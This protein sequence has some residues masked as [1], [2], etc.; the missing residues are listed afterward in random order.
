LRPASINEIK[1]ELS[2]LQPKKLIEL[3]LR[4]AK[5][6]KEN[7]ELLTYLLFEAQNEQAFVEAINRET[8]ERFSELPKATTYLTT[9]SLRKIL[10][11]ITKFSRYMDSKES[12][13]DTRI[14]FC[15]ML[16]NSGIRIQKDK[17]IF[18]LYTRQLL[19]LNALKESVHEDLAF[20]YG[21]QLQEL[22][23]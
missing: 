19:K 20:D 21:K 4:L 16:K 1:Q 6:K 15:A 11:S 12:E 3:C 9:K 23:I 2:A 14:H 22:R 13:M 5:Y 17:A 8:D 7:K 18:N 10:R